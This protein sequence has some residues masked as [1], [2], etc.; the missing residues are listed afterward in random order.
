MASRLD[1]RN[2]ISVCFPAA[3]LGDEK[4]PKIS[5]TL[6]TNASRNSDDKTEIL[7]GEER[8]KGEVERYILYFVSLPCDL[9]SNYL[10]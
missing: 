4:M 1:W 8:W 2:S 10:G 3:W 5:N 6:V 9:N 7:R